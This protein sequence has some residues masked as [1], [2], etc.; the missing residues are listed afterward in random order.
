MH[1]Y[2]DS[3]GT[4]QLYNIACAYAKLGDTKMALQALSDCLSNGFD[5]FEAMKTVRH[6]PSLHAPPQPA[7]MISSPLHRE[8]VE[9]A[10]SC[11]QRP[12]KV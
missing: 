6:T 3:P 9:V 2:R 5:N 4:S 8:T 1:A 10:G 12:A 7:C 11:I